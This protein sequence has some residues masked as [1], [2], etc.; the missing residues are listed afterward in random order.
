MTNDLEERF[1]EAG[2]ISVEFVRRA[3]EKGFAGF[4]ANVVHEAVEVDHALG[5]LM[6]GRGSVGGGRLDPDFDDVEWSD[7]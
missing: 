6:I 7:W 4:D 1:P 5:A 3:G 2:G